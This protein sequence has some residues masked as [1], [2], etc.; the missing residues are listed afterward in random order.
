[1]TQT[2]LQRNKKKSLLAA[3]LLFLRERK[4]LVLLLLLVLVAST[5]FVSPSSWVTGLPGGARFAAGV[6]WVA[7]K[8]GVDTSKWGLSG[9]DRRS[10]DDL[11]AAFRAAKAGANGAGAVGW[12]AFFGRGSGSAAGA[13]SLDFVKGSKDDL[14]GNPAAGGKPGGGGPARDVAAVNPGDE[15]GG[16]DGQG[17][18]LTDGDLGGER[19]GWVKSAFAGGF[20]NGLLGGGSGD[21][22]LSGGAYAGRGFF[23]GTGGAASATGTD[24]AKSALANAGSV[25]VPK[26]TIVGA[27]KGRLSAIRAS[28]VQSRA[29]N[30]AA[31]AGDING[32]AAYKALL[33]GLTR[34]Q[35]V[36]GGCSSANP[37]SD[38]SCPVANSIPTEYATTNTGAIY[39]GNQVTG[40]TT[41][42]LTAPEVDTVQTPDLPDAGIAQGYEDQANQLQEQAKKCQDAQAQYGPQ[43]D[44]LNQQMQDLRDQFAAADCGSGGCSKS[45]ARHCQHIGDQMQGLCGQFSAVACQEAQAC[46][47]TC[48]NDC[49]GSGGVNNKSHYTSG[50]TT[51][52]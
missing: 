38:A 11:L 48:S 41:G 47:Q 7:G 25:S 10:Y 51:T 31:R 9:R 35:L 20:M 13:S 39:D 15:A 46:G 17:V 36:T 30:G 44:Q 52:E 42:I 26:S 8:L 4:I 29:M 40:D 5:V 14:A 3:L 6:A 1:M 49:A 18:A 24:I 21:A 37:A 28:E 33:H 12:G 27:A 50:G 45:K 23:S 34:A 16:K 22:A 19:E 32:R 2:F 43:E